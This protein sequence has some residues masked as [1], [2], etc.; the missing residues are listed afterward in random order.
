MANSGAVVGYVCMGKEFNEKVFPFL[1]H[2]PYFLHGALVGAD[3]SL[4]HPI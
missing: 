4:G 1:T 3:G 2:H